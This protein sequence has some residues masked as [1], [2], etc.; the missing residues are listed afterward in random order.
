MKIVDSSSKRPEDLALTIQNAISFGHRNP[1][2]RDEIFIQVIKQMTFPKDADS[3]SV[4]G[5]VIKGW[6]MLVLLTGSFPPSKV[7]KK[8]M[9]KAIIFILKQLYRVYQNIYEHLFSEA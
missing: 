5:V 8:L 1:E 7:S 9:S 4:D 6:Q 2:L 3:R